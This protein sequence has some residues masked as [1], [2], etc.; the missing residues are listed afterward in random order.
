MSEESVT[1]RFSAFYADHYALVLRACRRRLPSLVAAEDAASEVFRVA[2][3]KYPEDGDPGIAWVYAIVRNVVGDEY[4]RNARQLL[5]SE[6]IAARVADRLE[7][8]REP[9]FD[10]RRALLRLRESD[11]ELLFM[12]YW[13]DLSGP[14]LAEVLGITVQAVWVRLNRARLALRRELGA[15]SG[16]ARG[17][18]TVSDGRA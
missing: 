7:G 15:A 18:G 5:L 6:K 16:P 10:L 12:A 4:R 14:Q 9:D 11:R 2:W 3:S 8:T 17:E 1:A 13:E